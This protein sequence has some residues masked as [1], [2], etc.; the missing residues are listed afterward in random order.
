[1]AIKNVR[2]LQ[3]D[4]SDNL[5]SKEKNQYI[6]ALANLGQR[7]TGELKGIE[8]KSF[9]FKDC[10]KST[11]DSSIDE[12]NSIGFIKY[13]R[14]GDT[15]KCLAGLI[16][17][18]ANGVPS[19]LYPTIDEAQ[20]YFDGYVSENISEIIKE[21]DILGAHIFNEDKAF[22]VQIN[23]ISYYNR[24]S[25]VKYEDG[26]Y[27]TL[28]LG[29]IFGADEDEDNDFNIEIIYNRFNA[30]TNRL[31]YG[32]RLFHFENYETPVYCLLEIDD[33]IL[34]VYKFDTGEIETSYYNDQLV[35][36][37]KQ[38]F[39]E[40]Y[41][42]TMKDNQILR[43][44]NNINIS[45]SDDL[46]SY[47]TIFGLILEQ[48]NNG[49]RR[50]QI[51][52]DIR[53]NID[54][55]NNQLISLNSTDYS[56]F[57]NYGFDLD[58]N[59][60]TIKDRISYINNDIIYVFPRLIQEYSNT[61]YTENIQKLYLQILTTIYNK[62]IYDEYGISDL[63]SVEFDDMATLFV[64]LDLK[65]FYYV[66][67][68]DTFNIFNINNLFVNVFAGNTYTNTLN[69]DNRVFNNLCFSSEAVL[70][71]KCI[72]ISENISY[73]EKYHN[74][75]D[76]INI[77]ENFTLPYIDPITYNWMINDNNS[78][79][80]STLNRFNNQF[81]FFIMSGKY[82]NESIQGR[83]LNDMPDIFGNM[84][85]VP[86]I[87]EIDP[88]QLTQNEINIDETYDDTFGGKFIGYAA[89]PKVDPNLEYLFANSIIVSLIP[90]SN[91]MH[92]SIKNEKHL[93]FAT[94]WNY[95]PT[96]SNDSKF[97][98]I[99]DND[100]NPFDL[101]YLLNLSV[102]N[103]RLNRSTSYIHRYIG[104]LMNERKYHNY[105]NNSYNDNIFVLYPEKFSTELP[106]G[107]IG[108]D[109]ALNC[110]VINNQLD[111]SKNELL[112]KNG[113]TTIDEF[114]NETKF[115]KLE[116]DS[117]AE[118]IIKRNENLDPD[119]VD[120]L[121]I[122]SSYLIEN[123]YTTNDNLVNED[124]VSNTIS[125]NSG[126]GEVIATTSDITV[127]STTVTTNLADYKFNIDIPTLNLSELFTSHNNTLNRI[128]ILTLDKNSAKSANND[129][130]YNTIIGAEQD[131]N[132]K[133]TFVIRPADINIDL[134]RKTMVDKNTAGM[135]R[136][137]E[138][139]LVE[140]NEIE[141]ISNSYSL[142]TLY[143]SCKKVGN[144]NFYIHNMSLLGLL[145]E[146]IQQVVP[147]DVENDIYNI[148]I[149]VAEQNIYYE[150]EIEIDEEIYYVF[151]LYKYF[152]NLGID[153]TTEYNTFY[154]YVARRN[155]VV[156]EY[157]KNIDD[158]CIKVGYVAGDS[159]EQKIVYLI[160]KKDHTKSI[161]SVD[162]IEMY[163]ALVDVQLIKVI[164]TKNNLP[165]KYI[166][167]VK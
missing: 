165:S 146:D 74:L 73:N 124:L 86:E 155:K 132:K 142:Q 72:N 58:K 1:M 22:D 116:Y 87:V 42:D 77:I 92:A 156:I 158:N 66:N 51:G 98:I 10:F 99:K 65:I 75:I 129:I 9:S 115:L 43:L 28:L 150:A 31:D 11:I 8:Y 57:L 5:E 123:E 108:N 63:N 64:P 82:E 27:C 80:S 13:F 81:I 135:F 41:Y 130:I 127:N 120:A 21:N 46:T 167:R 122:D 109:L 4:I 3:S 35:T 149:P 148:G 83:L 84:T 107:K 151:N 144:L 76:Y 131:I 106:D 117:T 121:T 94:L 111:I 136:K 137:Q 24:Y 44:F 56:L 100:D 161:F 147:N 114:S 53:L 159:N 14:N 85:Y 101:S 97:S 164:D 157:H 139:F 6:Q 38:Y 126:A 154:E 79:I 89:L 34:R 33:D 32:L 36:E 118:S 125:N 48:D 153:T 17:K 152:S 88:Y 143:E 39:Q 49:K 163:D 70:V 119:D 12:T 54:N 23:D 47:D 103:S 78:G 93:L 145:N 50:F 55:E 110:K 30:R 59:G 67:S 90:G 26:Y 52:N 160:I 60:I 62:F 166:I 91:I 29:K 16:D 7:N 25:V 141:L 96:A 61:Y 15:K 20:N 112:F 18:N 37:F 95:D 102:A 134:G 140:F 2:L 19:S 128:N 113:Q 69:F 45:S 105:V 133:S 40:S 138:K 71:N 162:D 104:M 68:E